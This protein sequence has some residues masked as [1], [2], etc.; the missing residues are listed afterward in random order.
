[1]SLVRVTAP[2]PLFDVAELKRH[3][4]VDTDDEDLEIDA[5]G[6]AVV[7]HLDGADGWLNRCLAPQTWDVSL[8]PEQLPGWGRPTWGHRRRHT[9]DWVLCLPLAPV[10]EIVWVKYLAAGDG[11]L[12][13]WTDFDVF[14]LGDSQGARLQPSYGSCWPDVRCQPDAFRIRFSA[15][16]AQDDGEDGTVEAVPFAIKA[17]LKLMVAD[18]Y[19]NRESQVADAA[20]AFA[21]NPTVGRL[22]T[23]YQFKPA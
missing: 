19:A 3:L 22:L 4:R 21:A 17:A 13:S 10:I 14:G 6:Q 12:T 20:A 11:A 16:Y 9:H 2:A 1:M 15:G 18:L 8:H 23:P 5:Y 7:D